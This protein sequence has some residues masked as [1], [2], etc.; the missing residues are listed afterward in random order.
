MDTTLNFKSDSTHYTAN[1]CIVWCFDDRFSALLGELIKSRGYKR[2]DLV[3]IAGGAQ[4]TNFILDQIGKSIKLHHTPRVIVMVHNEC[5]AYGGSTDPVFY[6]SELTNARD[7]ITKQFPEV[8]VEPVFAD[9][10][11]LKFL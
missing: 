8:T 4:D 10:D 3:K 1:A 9:F 7:A 2:V 5:G 11:R 6:E